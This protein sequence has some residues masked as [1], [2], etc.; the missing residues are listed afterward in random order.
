M[1][2]QQTS[3]DFM[4]ITLFPHCRVNHYNPYQDQS[5]NLTNFHTPDKRTEVWARKGETFIFA[6]N[7]LTIDFHNRFSTDLIWWPQGKYTY[8]FINIER[9]FEGA[10]SLP[11]TE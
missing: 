5:S 6:K 11:K 10:A 7:H 3:Q 2:N 8:L 1:D 4:H 9:Y